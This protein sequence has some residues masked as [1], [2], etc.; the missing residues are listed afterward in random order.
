MKIV[1]AS[2]AF[3]SYRVTRSKILFQL[4]KLP[5]LITAASSVAS[6]HIGGWSDC[7]T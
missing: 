4:Q 7:K 3:L 5:S 2:A 1:D 6:K